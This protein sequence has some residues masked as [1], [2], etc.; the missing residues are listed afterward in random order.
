MTRVRRSSGCGVEPQV[1]VDG[2][3]FPEGP[4]FDAEGNLY[5]CNRWDGFIAKVTPDLQIIRFVATGG[6]PNG[7]RFHRD[8]RLF[9]ADIGRREILAAYGDGSFAVVVDGY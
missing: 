4:N 8:G 2:Q 9:I 1:Y 3:R 6:K 7:A 5:V